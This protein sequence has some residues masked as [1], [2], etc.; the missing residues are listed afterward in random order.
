MTYL[1]AVLAVFR[2]AR[3]FALEDGPLNLF[4]KIQEWAEPR[5]EKNWIARGLLC[6]L[7]VGF[8]LS[9]PVTLIFLPLTP[10]LFVL[11]WLGIA[12]GAAAI[13]LIT[14]QK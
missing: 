11:T 3:M 7:C 6:P 2:A 5:Q 14:E 10:A 1:L 12:G 9:L 13:Y 8:W 4:S